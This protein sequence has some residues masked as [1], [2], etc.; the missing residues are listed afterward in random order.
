MIY[1]RC[2]D[3]SIN[4]GVVWTKMMIAMT[5]TILMIHMSNIMICINVQSEVGY[6]VDDDC[7]AGY[8]KRC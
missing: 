7:F 1:N 8:D 2:H 3:V 6:N 5:K 4:C